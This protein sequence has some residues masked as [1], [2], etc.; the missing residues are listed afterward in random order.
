MAY[1]RFVAI[2]NPLRYAKLMNKDT[3]V[4]M[5]G[6]CCTSA[7]VHALLH[8]MVTTRLHF[9]HIV[10]IPHF[11]CDIPPLLEVSSSDTSL[12][13]LL[14]FTEGSLVA[15]VPSLV[16]VLSYIRIT[17][18]I[19]HI[20]SSTG[21]QKAFSTCASHLTVFFLFTASAV[22]MYFKPSSSYSRNKGK[23]ITLMYTAF[24]PMCNPY[25]YC[26]RNSKVK[27]ALRRHLCH[28]DKSQKNR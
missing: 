18:A 28:E 24:T 16:T 11:F 12:N 27:I 2:C 17:T 19:L 10:H 4:A 6:I 25:I 1:D 13:E 14:V 8:A 7:S 15:L 5:C 22:S 21:R 23:F 9:T 20:H 26:L 3:C